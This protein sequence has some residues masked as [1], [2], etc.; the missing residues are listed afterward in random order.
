MS[1]GVA[2]R[3]NMVDTMLKA[4]ADPAAVE[5]FRQDREDRGEGGR[6]RGIHRTERS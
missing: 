4:G 1:A 3:D 5:A 2:A 6:T